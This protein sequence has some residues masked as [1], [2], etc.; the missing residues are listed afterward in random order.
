MEFSLGWTSSGTV[1]SLR[2]V[3]DH[4]GLGRFPQLLVNFNQVFANG[5][6]LIKFPCSFEALLAKG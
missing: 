4:G 2:H 5:G 3:G 1:K 6:R